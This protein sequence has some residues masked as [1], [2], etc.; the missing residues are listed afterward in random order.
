[1]FCFL[2]VVVPR[3]FIRVFLHL[4]FMSFSTVLCGIVCNFCSRSD[5]PSYI[6][7]RVG[8]VANG[9]FLF[10]IWS[11]VNI[12]MNLMAVHWDDSVWYMK[13]IEWKYPLSNFWWAKKWSGKLMDFVYGFRWFFLFPHPKLYTLFPS[14]HLSNQQTNLVSVSVLFDG[15]N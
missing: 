6:V 1:M 2:I 3:T 11:S 5:H 4:S 10:A 15:I 9:N 12:T 7:K 14:P 13:G 8:M